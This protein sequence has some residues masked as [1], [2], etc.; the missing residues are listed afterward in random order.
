[1]RHCDYADR[2]NFRRGTDLVEL[3]RL[4]TYHPGR[5]HSGRLGA[6]RGSALRALPSWYV[7]RNALIGKDIGLADSASIPPVDAWIGRVIDQRYR[8]LER[9]GQGAM[10]V[11]YRVEHVRMGK[12]AALKL[13]HQHLC[14]DPTVSQR[15]HHE[16]E[17]IS[18]L[19]HPNIVQVFDFG[20]IDQMPFLVMEYLSGMNLGAVIRRDG[21]RPF[22]RMVPMLVQICDA[23]TEAHALGIIHRDLKPE[24]IQISRTRSGRDLTKVLDFGLAK[25]VRATLPP[26]DTDKGHLVG[27]PYYMAPE[28]IRGQPV[29]QRCDIY[30]LAAVAY[31]S[32]TGD[33]PFRASTPVGVLTK[34][35][36]EDVVPPSIRAPHLEIPTAIDAVIIKAMAKNPAHR[37]A[38]ADAFKRGLLDVANRFPT[39][40]TTTP[41]PAVELRAI[42]PEPAVLSR[43]DLAFERRLRRARI[44]RPIIILMLLAAL[45]AGVYWFGVRSQPAASPPHEI[46]PNNVPAQATPLAAGKEISGRLGKRLSESESDRDW[47]RI[48]IAG[49]APQLL[50]AEV[51][52]LPNMDITLEVYDARGDRIVASDS[53]GQGGG[54]IITN[55]P[56]KPGRYFLLVREVWRVGTAPTENVTDVYRLAYTSRPLRAGWEEEPNDSDA[57]ANPLRTGTGVK[58]ILG[59]NSDQDT[60][61]IVAPKGVLS[62]SVS[63]VPDVD[64]VVEIWRHGAQ[65]PRIVDSGGPSQPERISAIKTDGQ[66]MLI[67]LRRKRSKKAKRQLVAGVERPYELRV[68]LH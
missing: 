28:Q 2:H 41:E 54:E 52:G 29:D 23:L 4:R 18:K 15:F 68:W 57:Q 60:F 42:G 65:R 58:G 17:A 36:T 50:R 62:A 61:R 14:A 59:T 47:Y 13:L 44:V 46:E 26:A 3:I 66:P 19:S 21:P 27:T 7:G 6:N 9:I 20:Q 30:S 31:R 45:G 22:D 33:P 11:V 48:A 5:D 37:F 16:A 51:S 12:I 63:A 25:M 53:T 8:V 35:I 43:E 40:A 10:G 49:Q 24:N 1:M 34:H 56:L 38:T 39:A 55:W 67:R 64:L 32:L